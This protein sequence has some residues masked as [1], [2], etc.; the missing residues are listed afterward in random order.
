[1][2]RQSETPDVVEEIE[3]GIERFA[4]WVGAN[5]WLSVGVVV[6]ALAVVAGVGSYASWQVSREEA[7][8]DALDRVRSA[9]LREM[10]AAPGALEVPELANPRAAQEIRERYL[11]EFQAVAESQRGTVAGTLA[12]LESADLLEALERSDEVAA[13]VA[14][15]RDAAQN[16]MLRAMV[17]RRLG[18]LHEDA[19]RWSEAAAAHA[20]AAA[21]PEYPLRAWALADAA[22]C[23]LSAG[24]AAEALALYEQ[25]EREAPDLAL[26]DHEAAQLREL[27]ATQQP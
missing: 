22:R 15:A 13:A 2:A 6:G 24:R 1:V 21:V 8:S 9:Y 7:A 20:A 17:E 18:Y 4:G 23:E 3:S 5:L 16:P 14:E 12:L 26:P 10:G 11:G 19:G 25:L 27:R